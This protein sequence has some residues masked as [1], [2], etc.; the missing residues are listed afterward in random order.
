MSVR[1]DWHTANLQP[2][3]HISFAVA[4]RRHRIRAMPMSLPRQRFTAWRIAGIADRVGVYV[5]WLGEEIIYIGRATAGMRQRQR[6]AAGALVEQ[7]GRQHG[8]LRF[9]AVR[10]GL[11][12]GEVH[13]GLRQARDG[14]RPAEGLDAVEQPRAGRH[15]PTLDG[16]RT[17]RSGATPFERRPT[18][19]GALAMTYRIPPT[20]SDAK[21]AA[22]ASR[23]CAI[24]GRSILVRSGHGARQERTWPAVI[25]APTFVCDN[26]MAAAAHILPNAGVL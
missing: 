14:G 2:P 11:R 18:R 26:L 12:L 1:F 19:A 15:G 7:R 23:S 5:L 17:A 13:Q 6:G 3:C 4:P 8:T 9:F 16:R 24:G 22:S 20:A 25:A 21:A 10:Q